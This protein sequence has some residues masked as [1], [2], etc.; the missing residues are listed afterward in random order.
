MRDFT[1]A[2][3]QVIP[4]KTYFYKSLNKENQRATLDNTSEM[5]I[6]SC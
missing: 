6:Q 1:V 3:S 5:T 2:G 4:I